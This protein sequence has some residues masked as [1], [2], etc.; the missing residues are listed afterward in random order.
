MQKAGIVLGANGK[1]LN[2]RIEVADVDAAKFTELAEDADRQVYQLGLTVLGLFVQV[3]RAST[4]REAVEAALRG[5]RAQYKVPADPEDPTSRW[6]FN[7]GEKAWIYEV[8]R[9]RRR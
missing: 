7:A 1:P 9:P 6:L 5:L 2:G 8:G 4:A 3:G